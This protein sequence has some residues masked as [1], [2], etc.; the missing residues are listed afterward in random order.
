MAITSRSIRRRVVD[1]LLPLLLRSHAKRLGAGDGSQLCGC[2][3]EPCENAQRS[4]NGLGFYV[5]IAPLHCATPVCGKADDGAVPIGDKDD[6]DGTMR[7]R[8]AVEQKREAAEAGTTAEREEETMTFMKASKILFSPPKV[9]KRLGLDFQIWQFL[10]ALLPPT[11][12]FLVAQ[13]VRADIRRWEREIEEQEQ[14]SLAVG[15]QEGNTEG[16]GKTLS[17][18]G[19]RPVVVHEAAK[20]AGR[21][22]VSVQSEVIGL[23]ERI[24][25][26]EEK[27]KS[28]EGA[29]DNQ[30]G[31]T[32][33]GQGRIASQE[34]K[35]QTL[36]PQNHHHQSNR[37]DNSNPQSDSGKG[38][39]SISTEPKLDRL[40][41]SIPVGLPGGGGGGGGVGGGER[42]RRGG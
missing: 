4:S 6:D 1:R 28:M 2:S 7:S 33:A 12:V 14:A 5:R 21:D 24:Q 19:G 18:G 20:V 22:L 30:G 25:L 32:R 37:S 17:G 27:L 11:A 23:R 13:L 38:Q 15:E 39:L 26:L 9:K 41:P 10:M 36:L 29:A 40:K 35:Q 42:E 8:S 34:S 31:Q 3:G 16:S